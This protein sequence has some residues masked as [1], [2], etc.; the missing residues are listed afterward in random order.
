[1]HTRSVQGWESGANYPTAESLQLLVAT[2]LAANGFT[3]AHE[4]AEAAALW[5][6]AE[7]ESNRLRLPFDTRWFADLVEQ[8]ASAKRRRAATAP[9]FTSW[10]TAPALPSERIEDWGDAPRITGFHDRI[11]ELAALKHSVVAD[12]SRIVALLGMSGIGK[13]ILAARLAEDLTTEFERIYWRSLRDAPPT[14]DWLAGAIAFLSDHRAVLPRRETARLSLLLDLLRERRCLLVLDGMD[15][16]LQPR[17]AG[18]AYCDGCAGYGTLVQRLGDSRHLSCLLLTSREAP[19]E[20]GRLA[21]EQGAMLSLAIAG[22]HVAD[23]RVFLHDD[24]LVGNAA[25]WQAL[26]AIYGGNGLALKLAGDSIEHVFG[27]DIAAFLREA[28]PFFGAIERML[29]GQIDRL[30]TLELAIVRRLAAT[31]EPISFADMAADLEPDVSTQSAIEAVEALQRRSLLVEQRT[32]RGLSLQPVVLEYV[33]SRPTDRAAPRPATTD[34]G[35]N[36]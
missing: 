16:V 17:N 28:Q 35:A 29:G 21:G 9:A 19:I 13:T 8:Q 1:M 20:L 18:G 23:V 22:M 11:S 2:Y 10:T 12:R 7:R 33:R 4:R 26:V 32:P 27:G 30:S 5:S 3:F 15:A 25:D 6:A 34:A 14:T 36:G 31:D 24:E